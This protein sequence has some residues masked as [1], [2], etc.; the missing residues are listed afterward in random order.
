[1]PDFSWY[2]IPKQEIIN[3][4]TIKYR[5]WPYNI[6]NGNKIYKMAMKSSIFLQDPKI[7]SQI[8]IFFG[9]K[10]YH[11]ATLCMITM[12]KCFYDLK[13]QTALFI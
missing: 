5:K 2:I 1:L 12:D 8:G 7:F 6:P 9:L 10:I 4:M 3:Q 13:A 11:L